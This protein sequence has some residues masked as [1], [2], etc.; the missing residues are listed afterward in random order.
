MGR[1]EVN[2]NCRFLV[3]EDE[4]FV[5]I[6]IEHVIQEL[7]HE[8]IGIAA[9]REAAL[10]YGAQAD[11]ALVDINLRDGATGIEIGR[12]LASRHDVTVVFM[13][14]NPTQLGDGVP[15]TLGVIGKPVADDELRASIRYA[16]A[17]YHR[18]QDAE[19]PSRL[20]LFMLAAGTDGVSKAG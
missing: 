13:T 1:F 2:E 4:I 18:H 16:V 12:E 9:D 10:S 11:I 3:V 14:A 19:P 17:A 7:G 15:G 20:H 8:C 6:E 5:A